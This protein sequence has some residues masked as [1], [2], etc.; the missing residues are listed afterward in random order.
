[1]MAKAGLAD[2]MLAHKAALKKKREE[3]IASMDEHLSPA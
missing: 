1:M 2:D 3:F